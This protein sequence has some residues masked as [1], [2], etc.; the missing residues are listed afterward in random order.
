MFYK[1][2]K[3]DP[4]SLIN[5]IKD[6]GIKQL[7]IDCTQIN[8]NKR[9]SAQKIIDD[10]SNVYNQPNY[11]SFLLNYISKK[12]SKKNFTEKLEAIEYDF[13]TLMEKIVVGYKIPK[14]NSVHISPHS[15]NFLYFRCFFLKLSI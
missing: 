5:T 2:G 9:P 14:L 11:F 6:E 4:S 10:W 3:Y 15:S 12:L 13:E 1:K 7:I 8:P